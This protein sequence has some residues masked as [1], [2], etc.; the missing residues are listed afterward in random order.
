[1]DWCGEERGKKKEMVVEVKKHEGEKCRV[2]V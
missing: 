1:L 2:R